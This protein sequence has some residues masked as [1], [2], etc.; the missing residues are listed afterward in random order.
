MGASQNPTCITPAL[1][2]DKSPQNRQS[3]CAAILWV[4]AAGVTPAIP[5]IES[6]QMFR[7]LISA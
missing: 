5:Q 4:T 1:T 6:Q 2:I 3:H 7:Q